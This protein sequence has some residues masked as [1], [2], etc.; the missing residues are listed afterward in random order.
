M[1]IAYHK[2]RPVNM[3][4]FEKDQHAFYVTSHATYQF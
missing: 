3:F 2:L 1:V 4:D